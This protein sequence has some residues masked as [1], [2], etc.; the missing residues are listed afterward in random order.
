[1]CV[2]AEQPLE[3]H[4]D[5]CFEVPWEGHAQGAREY[6]LVIQLIFDPSHQK[7]DVF[8]RADL[9]RGFHVVPVGPEV[10]VLGPRGHRRTRLCSAEF[11]Q[12]T[13]EDID[14]IV[15]LDGVD[16]E[17][18]VQIL[19]RR[20]LDSQ[21]HIATA[22]GHP[23]DLLEAVAARALLDLLLLLERLGAIDARRDLRA[24]FLLL[25][26]NHFCSYSSW[27]GV[28]LFARLCKKFKLLILL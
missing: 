3:D 14:F 24:E 28:H 26:F 7:V 18:L 15:K 23:R 27:V 8:A 19:T 11:C 16:G 17:P 12:Y 1:M 20:Q 21:L 9:E 2:D 4:L 6:F 13:I 10:L 5:Y 25:G 22:E